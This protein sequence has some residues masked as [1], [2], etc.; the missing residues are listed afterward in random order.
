MV[1]FI[2]LFF[3]VV[4]SDF[5]DCMLHQ[6]HRSAFLIDGILSSIGL[7]TLIPTIRTACLM[8]FQITG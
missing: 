4:A 7:T 8:Y 5:A 3:Y 1:H 2:L 6:S